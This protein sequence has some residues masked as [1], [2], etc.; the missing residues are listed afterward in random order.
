MI[1]GQEVE[2]LLFEETSR[3]MIF[4]GNLLIYIGLIKKINQY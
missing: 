1:M 3:K 2:T 4:S